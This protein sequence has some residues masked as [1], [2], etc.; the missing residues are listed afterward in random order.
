M[1]NNN[2]N[3]VWPEKVNEGQKVEDKGRRIGHMETVSFNCKEN[4]KGRLEENFD[5]EKVQK[6]RKSQNP[7]NPHCSRRI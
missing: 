1:N 5:P 2:K 6:K 3:T 4:L 7:L